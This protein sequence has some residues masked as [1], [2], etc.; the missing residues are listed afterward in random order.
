MGKFTQDSSSVPSTPSP[1][2]CLRSS[3]HSHIFLRL[4]DST[5]FHFLF[6]TAASPR[7]DSLWLPSKHSFFPSFSPKKSSMTFILQFNPVQRTERFS[8][9]EEQCGA[10]RI[11]KF[12]KG[13]ARSLQI[14]KSSSSSPS[15]SDSRGGWMRKRRGERRKSFHKG[16]SQFPAAP[17]TWTSSSPHFRKQLSPLQPSIPTYLVYSWFWISEK[18]GRLCACHISAGA[19]DDEDD[20]YVL[21]SLQ[22]EG[23][24]G[25]PGKTFSSLLH[26]INIFFFCYMPII[27][28]LHTHKHRHSHVLFCIHP[29]PKKTVKWVFRSAFVLRGLSSFPSHSSLASWERAL[30]LKSSANDRSYPYF[31]SRACVC[32]CVY[33]LHNNNVYI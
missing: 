33:A 21:A 22:K 13:C 11:K 4:E 9:C 12:N 15:S 30:L 27:F 26:S 14:V 24:R 25:T 6:P 19:D 18:K 8:T 32:E 17:A 3:I 29:S 7:G 5:F 2:H 23:K 16:L 10:W 20:A 31:L 28:F 1:G